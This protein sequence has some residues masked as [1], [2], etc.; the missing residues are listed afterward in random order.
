MN[1]DYQLF[2]M[3]NQFAGQNHLLDQ[4]VMLFSKYG[5]IL[6]GLVFVWLWLSKSGNPIDNRKIVLYAL[7]ITIIV[8]GINKVIELMYFRPRPFV[9]YTV[10]LLSDKVSSDPSFPSN[11]SAGAFAMACA[12]FWYRRKIGSVLLIMAFFMALSR[13][14]IGVHYPLDVT[15]GAIIALIVTAAVISQ[16]RLL[17]PLYQNLIQGFRRSKDQKTYRNM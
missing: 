12:L 1:V 13:I 7:T 16:R 11:H 17:D 10:N 3:L 5:P 6:F 9:T 14:Y 8:L 4:T 2:D 15:A